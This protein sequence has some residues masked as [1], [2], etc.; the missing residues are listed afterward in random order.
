[1]LKTRLK[2]VQEIIDK[3]SKI[4]RQEQTILELRE[5]IKAFET[6]SEVI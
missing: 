2:L 6:K 4:A 3:D 5:I 1:M